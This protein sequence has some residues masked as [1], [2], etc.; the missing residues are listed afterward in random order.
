MEHLVKNNIE[1]VSVKIVKDN[2]TIAVKN[3][4]HFEPSENAER[5]SV[6]GKYAFDNKVLIVDGESR[7]MYVILKLRVNNS[8]YSLFLDV[9]SIRKLLQMVLS[10]LGLQCDLANDGA[11]AVQAIVKNPHKYDFIF[12]D[13]MMPNMSGID[14]T[15]QIREMGY[16]KIILGL[17]GNTMDN[18]TMEFE[19]AGADVI[20]W[21]PIKV[22]QCELVLEHMRNFG[23]QNTVLSRSLKKK[24]LGVAT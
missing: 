12:M 8:L 19:N 1:G 2:E 3:P 23:T 17:T 16:D 24:V 20:F 21:K 22:S 5:S 11:E 4:Q 7:K 13:N 15:K 18:E 14:A 6:T 10:K 9:P